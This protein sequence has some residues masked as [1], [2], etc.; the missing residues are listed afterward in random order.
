MKDMEDCAEVL[1][2]LIET[3]ESER[4]YED[5]KVLDFLRRVTEDA[6]EEE[7]MGLGES[8]YMAIHAA[9]RAR[10]IEEWAGR[11]KTALDG[12]YLEGK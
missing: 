6:T 2:D 1:Q 5:S 8:L 4:A 9:T 11:L 7:R 12:C 10:T 3:M